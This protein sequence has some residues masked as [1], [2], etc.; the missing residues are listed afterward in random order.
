MADPI[1]IGLGLF[2]FVGGLLQGSGEKEQ[3]EAEA[4]AAMFNARI[5]R[6]NSRLSREKATDDE[7]RLRIIGAKEIGDIRTGYAS[8]G[9]TSEGSAM[10]V[11]RESAG[12]IELDALTIRYRGD[13][14]AKVYE[15]QARAEDERAGSARRM[16]KYGMASG[17]LSGG[18]SLA[19]GFR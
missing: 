5:A 17:L 18:A 11:L 13:Q 9:V 15:L 4:R 12:N 7:R 6:V 19:R 3:A 10:E 2:G 16:G 1:S 8:S 14:E